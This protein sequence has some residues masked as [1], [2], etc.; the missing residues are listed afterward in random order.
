MQFSQEG[1]YAYGSLEEDQS[2]N[3]RRSSHPGRSTAVAV[4]GATLVFIANVF[5]LISLSRWSLTF[6]SSRSFTASIMLAS[7]FIA[8]ISAVL[9]PCWVA[10][11]QTTVRFVDAISIC[12]VAAFAFAWVFHPYLSYRSAFYVPSVVHLPLMGLIP[13]LVVPFG[14]VMATDRRPYRRIT[15]I[16][17]Q[18]LT[19]G[20]VLVNCAIVIRDAST[21]SYSGESYGWT[22]GL[23]ASYAVYAIAVALAFSF[24]REGCRKASTTSLASLDAAVTQ[25]LMNPSATVAPSPVFQSVTVCMTFV[26]L[27]SFMITC[28]QA[29]TPL[30]LAIPKVGQPESLSPTF[31]TNYPLLVQPSTESISV[32]TS[33]RQLKAGFEAAFGINV[34]PMPSNSFVQLNAIYCSC[35]AIRVIGF[36]LSLLASPLLPV[37]AYFAGIVVAQFITADFPYWSALYQYLNV[38]WRD[39]LSPATNAAYSCALVIFAVAALLNIVWSATTKEESYNS[40]LTGTIRPGPQQTAQF[41]YSNYQTPQNDAAAY[42]VYVSGGAGYDPV[43][44]SQKRATW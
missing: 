40:A 25:T 12:K 20:G 39:G 11:T 22:F 6:D 7:G 34:S 23:V 38:A 30:W 16:F 41:A 19:I 4:V 24:V 35:E 2:P 17:S 37:I 14:R 27:S 43:A 1:Y 26:V 36:A 44:Q 42:N 18:L 21:P 28:L 9:L 5:Q 3:Q 15:L 13:L 33:Y 29:L 32:S 31:D 10:L 8:V